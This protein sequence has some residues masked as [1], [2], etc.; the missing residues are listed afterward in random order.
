MAPSFY[1]EHL[2]AWIR[3]GLLVQCK[4]HL[5]ALLLTGQPSSL[6]AEVDM[7]SQACAI[8]PTSQPKAV[9]DSGSKVKD[10]VLGE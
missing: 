10:Y 2:H 5:A 9:A 4:L 8:T 6:P 7:S 1:L 3:N